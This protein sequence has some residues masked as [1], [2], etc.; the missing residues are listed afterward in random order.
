MSD[1]FPD[2]K[3]G[4][5]TQRHKHMAQCATSSSPAALSLNLFPLCAGSGLSA[6]FSLSC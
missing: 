2:P 4:S 5:G 6:L 1:R 3:S